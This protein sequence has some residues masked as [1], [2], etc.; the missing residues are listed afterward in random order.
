MLLYQYCGLQIVEILLS[1][2]HKNDVRNSNNHVKINKI[3]INLFISHYKT[4]HGLCIRNL[5]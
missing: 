3:K 1:Y 4:S 2:I 5:L